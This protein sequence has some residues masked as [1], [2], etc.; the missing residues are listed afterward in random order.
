[1]MMPGLFMASVTNYMRTKQAT[2]AGDRASK[3]AAQVR[4]QNEA[5]TCDIE[6]LLMITEALWTFIK[7]QHGLSDEHLVKMVQDIDLRDGK[8][9]G[10]VAKQ[11][12]PDCPHCGRKLMKNHSI[13]IYCGA[14]VNRDP[15]ER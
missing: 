8:L 9:D 3:S 12:N 10:K 1:M 6:K 13:C 2:Y 15:F 14:V 11:E 5:I 7:G 4:I